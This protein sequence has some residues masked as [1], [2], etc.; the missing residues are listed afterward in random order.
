MSAVIAAFS[1]GESVDAQELFAAYKSFEHWVVA[2]TNLTYEEWFATP[3]LMPWAPWYIEREQF[4]HNGDG[5]D[6]WK[7]WRRETG[8]S[9]E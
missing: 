8:A 1:R 2:D 6:A 4:P 5:F 3:V 7:K 9:V